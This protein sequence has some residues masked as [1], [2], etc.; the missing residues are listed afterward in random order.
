MDELETYLG[1]QPNIPQ[2]L[3]N[4]LFATRYSILFLPTEIQ[5]NVFYTKSLDAPYELCSIHSEQKGV[6][7]LESNGEA[8]RNL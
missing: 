2:Q 4:G 6:N 1:F 5:L 8:L 7:P 3:E